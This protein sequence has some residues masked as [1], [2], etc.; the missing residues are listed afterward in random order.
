M[1][2]IGSAKAKKIKLRIPSFEPRNDDSKSP[3][4]LPVPAHGI[5]RRIGT[6]I[7]TFEFDDELIRRICDE[8]KCP[9][10]TKLVSQSAG[11][12]GRSHIARVA[13]YC[14]SNMND[15]V[16]HNIRKLDEFLSLVSRAEI[17]LYT[18]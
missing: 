16:P 1:P 10:L 14:I 13:L 12:S 4:R 2:R 18:L 17:Q 7:G 5:T 15:C 3:H 11:P 8:K 6:C 9:L